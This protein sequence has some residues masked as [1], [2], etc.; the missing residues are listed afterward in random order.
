MDKTKRF[1]ILPCYKYT[2][3]LKIKQTTSYRGNSFPGRYW[4]FVSTDLQTG[5]FQGYQKLDQRSWVVT[6]IKN[7]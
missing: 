4:P 3:F 6:V 1:L 5:D 2:K 7:K